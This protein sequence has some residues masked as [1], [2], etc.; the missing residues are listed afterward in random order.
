MGT[1]Q[2]DLSS[3]PVTSIR[4][5]TREWTT[6]LSSCPDCSIGMGTRELDNWTTEL[7]QLSSIRDGM[8]KDG[9]RDGVGVRDI[10]TRV[11][12]DWTTRTSLLVRSCPVGWDDS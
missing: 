7:V 4:D 12:W 3:C 10:G 1:G 5:G 2:L 6:K 9:K 8:G 11:T